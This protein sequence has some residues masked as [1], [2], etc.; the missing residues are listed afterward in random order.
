MYTQV[1]IVYLR[2][3]VVNNICYM[4]NVATMRQQYVY[5]EVWSMPM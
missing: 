4:H 1:S 5:I 2:T 3:Y